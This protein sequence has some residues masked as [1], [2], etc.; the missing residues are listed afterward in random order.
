MILPNK[1]S[2][3]FKVFPKFD[4]NFNIE[5]FRDDFKR[6]FTVSEPLA[7]QFAE[8]Q[9]SSEPQEWD[10]L[11]MSGFKVPNVTQ[12]VFNILQSPILNRTTT[13][14]EFDAGP[15]GLLVYMYARNV[16]GNPSRFQDDK[17]DVK[18]WL[19]SMPPEPVQAK[20]P[21]KSFW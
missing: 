2:P 20:Q 15:K 19:K 10:L 12:T 21:R 9:S 8:S 6:V 18:E 4:E 16:D 3:W 1:S 13:T 7:M 5:D 11:G 17:N 14:A